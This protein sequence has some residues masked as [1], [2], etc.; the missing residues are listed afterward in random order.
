[1]R[2][3]KIEI[4]KLKDVRILTREELKDVLGGGNPETVLPPEGCSGG[5]CNNVN[6]TDMCQG[7]CTCSNGTCVEAA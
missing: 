3:L 1:M 4:P 5:T 7:T 2:K 6:P